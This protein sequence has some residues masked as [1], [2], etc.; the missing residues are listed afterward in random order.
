MNFNKRFENL[1]GGNKRKICLAIALY[2]DP[3]I[4]LLDECSTGLDPSSRVAMVDTIKNCRAGSTIFT[5]HSM[6]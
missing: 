3:N 6:G 2:G 1:S 5:T 4:R